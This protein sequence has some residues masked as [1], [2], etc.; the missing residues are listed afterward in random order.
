MPHRA[1]ARRT[2]ACLTLVTATV[3]GCQKSAPVAAK[4]A[5]STPAPATALPEAA[6]PTQAVPTRS[7]YARLDRTS[8][9][10]L[11]TESALPWFWA[12]DRN[13]DETLQPDE[14]AVLTGVGRESP[15]YWQ[16]G[17][18]FTPAF[19]TAYE[20]LVARKTQ[21]WPMDGLEP[22]ERR[23]REAVL[24]ELRQ[25]RPTLLYTDLRTA[26][27]Q[28]KAFA[29]HILAAAR[30]IEHLYARQNG[31]DALARQLPAD[32]G[33]SR[34][35][36]QRNQGPWCVAPATEKNVDC[37]ALASRPAR[38]SG[39]YPSDLAA[40][41]PKLCETLAARPDA[42]GLLDPFVVVR[43]AADGKLL[44]VKYHDAYAPDMDAIAV[45]LDAA[46]AAVQSPDEAALQAY[47]KAAA[48]AF[49]TG[50]WQPADEA[51]AKMNAT[52]SKWYLRIAPDETY[53]EPCSRKAGFQVSFARIDPGSLKWQTILDP[54][55]NDLEQAVA[56]LAGPPYVARK[57]DFHLPDFIQIVLNAGDS[58][59]PLGA[60]VGQSLPNWGPVA[61]EGRGRTVAMVNVGTDP[62]SRKALEGQ[63][64]SLF[65]KATMARFTTDPAPLQMSTVLHE[66]AHNLGPAHEYKAGGKT[67][68]DWFG[69]PLAATL[70]EL[71]AQ[72]AAL[73]LTDW[74]A[75]R[76]TID[77]TMRDQAHLADI[78]WG[79]GHIAG[80]MVDARGKPKPY[81]QLS[82]IQVGAL[83]Q[84]GAIQWKAEEKAANGQDVGCFE[85]RADKTAPAILQLMTRVAG[86]KARGDKADAEAM[87]KTFV[88]DPGTWAQLRDTIRQ[89]WLRVPK[90]SYVYAVALD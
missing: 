1:L 40:N 67:D 58:R 49:R 5:E 56:K 72:T 21:G 3:T 80:G 6:S 26:S 37:N 52:N 89:R 35:L 51:W 87:R 7:G 19:L 25:G 63:A 17:G 60:T 70:E 2:L 18:Q 64:A 33:P 31:V 15:M 24:Q 12:D 62:D 55:K 16:A 46:A 10:Q 61:N 66:A 39:I 78:A 8:F 86:I 79:F 59:S 42:K 22:P 69:G 36:F 20:G 9:N 23:R 81:S 57:V 43:K 29:G 48:Q 83:L 50:A 68:D 11:A 41:D 71:K 32:D 88:E 75:Q 74:L 38:L 65:C 27:P 34:A 14:L 77:E 90:A 84:A 54:L 53:F 76:G 73:Y 44:A 4:S 47:L 13:H 82:A 45:E 28:D 30:M 85:V